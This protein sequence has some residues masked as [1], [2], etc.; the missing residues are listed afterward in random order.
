MALVWHNYGT[1][2]SGLSLECLRFNELTSVE[3]GNVLSL[4]NAT[5]AASFSNMQHAELMAP[6]CSGSQ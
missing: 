6:V 4:W 3:G 2:K 1:P 5:V